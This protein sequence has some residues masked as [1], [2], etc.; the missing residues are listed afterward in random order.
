MPKYTVLVK[1]PV[2]IGKFKSEGKVLNVT[3]PTKQESAKIARAVE[4]GLLKEPV[5]PTTK[6][7]TTK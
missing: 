6:T 1:N 5:S 3:S 4:I 7:T 2:Q